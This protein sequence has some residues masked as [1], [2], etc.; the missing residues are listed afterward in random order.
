MRDLDPVTIHE[1]YN[2]VVKA[3]K[4]ANHIAWSLPP[5]S[6]LRSIL[7]VVPRK[8]SHDGHVL[9]LCSLFATCASHFRV[10]IIACEV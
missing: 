8:W 2:V 3:H 1:L 5:L 7:R 10:Q 9:R 6:R 4:S